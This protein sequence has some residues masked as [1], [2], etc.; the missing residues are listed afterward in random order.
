MKKYIFQSALF[1]A[2]LIV[3][4]VLL[5]E[6]SQAQQEQMAQLLF[7]Q[8]AKGVV[9]EKGTITLKGVSPTTLFFSDRPMRIAGH[10]TTEEFVQTWGEGKNSFASDPPNATLSIFQ[11][12]RDKLIDVVVK[13]SN[14][15]LEGDDLTYHVAILEGQ[16]PAKGEM[17]SLFIDII[18]LPFT[19]LSF[20]GVARRWTRR[21]VVVGATATT[22]A[23]ATSAA[24]GAAAASHPSTIVVTQPA[25]PPAA[26]AASPPPPAV[27]SLQVAEQKLKDLKTLFDQGLISESEYDAKKQQIL[28]G[29]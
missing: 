24:V 23:V 2:F 22:A 9:F 8:N 13:L 11:E 17:C 7:V 28:K 6:A 29:F 15:L 1:V 18:G 10:Y 19:P 20:A 3:W 16:M 4:T 25:P 5:P 27:P 21:A 14:P 12:D 26:P